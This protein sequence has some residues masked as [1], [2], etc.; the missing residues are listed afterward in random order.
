MEGLVQRKAVTN[1]NVTHEQLPTQ[2]L[3]DV[4]VG[5]TPR[6]RSCRLIKNIPTQKKI[7]GLMFA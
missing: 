1:E 6:K 7:H 2:E 5:K 4:K 3:L